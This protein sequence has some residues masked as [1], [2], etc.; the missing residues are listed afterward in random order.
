MTILIQGLRQE[1]IAARGD[2]VLAL[3][4][5]NLEI[6]DNEFLVI[7]GPSGCGKTTLLRIL[8]GLLSQSAGRVSCDGRTVAGQR[9]DVGVVF[10]EA[11]LLPWFTVLANVLL[12][13]RVQHRRSDEFRARAEELLDLVGLRQFMHRYP[14]ELSGGMQQRVAICRALIH[15]P[16]LLLMDEPFGALDA[17][18]RETMNQEL[19]NIWQARPKTVVFITH[20]IP[21]AVFLADRVA[22]FSPRPGRLSALIDVPLPRPRTLGMMSDL[23][24]IDVT[25]RLRSMFTS[26]SAFH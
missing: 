21:E 26:H 5:V 6:G 3:D 8:S 25:A 1:Y 10:Q 2:R 14:D 17:M 16:T 20:S 24:Y 13:V 7:V 12:P 18:T 22:V 9:R 15:D 23:R 4:N 11:R 19:L